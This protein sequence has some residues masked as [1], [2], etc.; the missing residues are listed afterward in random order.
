[1]LKISNINTYYSRIQALWDVS[2][3]IEK[4]EIFA[5]IG[6]NGA[7]KST[8]LKT[9][10][11]WIHPSSGT[12]E[13]Q[14]QRID[15]SSPQLIVGMGLSYIP[16]GG[17]LFPE[18]TVRENLEMG[19]YNI[20][21]WKQRQETMLHIFDI[22]PILKERQSQLARTLSGGEKQMLA[23][24][25]GLMSKPIL[26]MFDEPSYGLSPKYVKEVF[27]VIKSLSGQGI[28]ILLVEQNVRL[29][30]EIA[31][32]ACVIEN[33]RTAMAGDCKMLLTDSYIKKAY[34]GL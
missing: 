26:C 11:G 23:I 7:G 28:T 9:L 15:R 29:A 22:F 25:R 27:K 30:L 10:S 20:K 3:T 32:R 16:E 4:G 34:L 21:A 8:L 24:G 1:M 19:A 5:L 33:G 31:E 17:R 12:I 2:L 6:S 14:N 13:F 18:M